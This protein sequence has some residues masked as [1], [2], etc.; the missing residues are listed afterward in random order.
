MTSWR[1][2]RL[3]PRIGSEL[4]E[5]PIRVTDKEVAQWR[6]RHFPD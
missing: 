4:A 6:A 3:P 2:R 5:Q 1:I